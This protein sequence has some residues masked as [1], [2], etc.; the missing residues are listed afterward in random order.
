LAAPVGGRELAVF[1]AQAATL[2]ALAWGLGRA[3][4]RLGMPAVVGEVTGAC[5]SARRCWAIPRLAC[6]ACCSPTTRRRPDMLDAAGQVGV[7]LL[8]GRDRRLER[9]HRAG[10]V[11]LGVPSG[12][13]L[14]SVRFECLSR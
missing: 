13:G 4:E 14:G 8:M 5:W 3:A 6:T 11:G 9:S 12:P 7:L 10:F 1:L 2:M